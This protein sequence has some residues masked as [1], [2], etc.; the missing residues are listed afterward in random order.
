MKIAIICN[1][2]QQSWIIGKFAEKLKENC[3][4]LGHECDILNKPNSNFDINHHVYYRSYSECKNTLSTFMITH[5]DTNKKY[6]QLQKSL[7]KANLGICMSLDTTLDLLNRG[8]KK[9]KITYIHPAHDSNYNF[10]KTR[11][12]IFSNIYD[13]KRKNEDWLRELTDLISNEIFEFVFIG[14]GWENIAKNL[15]G[16]NFSVEHYE[17]SREN[18]DIQI[19]KTDYWLYLGFDEGSMSFLDAIQLGSKIICS[20]Q[21]FQKDLIEAIDHPFKT[22]LEFFEILKKINLQQLSKQNLGK[23]LSWINYTKKH[24]EIWNYLLSGNNDINEP[25]KDGIHFFLQNQKLENKSKNIFFKFYGLWYKLKNLIKI[26]KL[27]ILKWQK[28]P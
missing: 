18:Y 7:K 8:F 17:F 6:I 27:K 3:L 26:F 10:K 13:D 1:E 21:G 24:I 22:K 20:A 9:N 14:S 11:L 15:K 4:N 28:S 25:F 19:S 23:D 5:V 2:N 16:K 12:G